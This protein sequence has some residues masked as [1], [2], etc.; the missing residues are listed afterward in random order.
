MCGH[1]K[2]FHL[3]IIMIRG[4]KSL[5]CQPFLAKVISVV[6]KIVYLVHCNEEKSMLW[7]RSGTS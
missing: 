3:G 1:H 5:W 2:A 7:A 6:V 4:S